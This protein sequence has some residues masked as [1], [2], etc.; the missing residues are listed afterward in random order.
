M[1]PL[2]VSV[3]KVG[4]LHTDTGKH[5]LTR[6]NRGNPLCACDCDTRLRFWYTVE[7][8]GWDRK[9]ITLIFKYDSTMVRAMVTCYANINEKHTRWRMSYRGI[10]CDAHVRSDICAQVYACVHTREKSKKSPKMF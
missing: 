7:S 6:S 5:T 4:A 3:H 9:V 1:V 10:V 2:C 8:S